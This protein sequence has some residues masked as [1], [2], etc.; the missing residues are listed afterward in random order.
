MSTPYLVGTGV[1]KLARR[2]RHVTLR[3]LAIVL[4][5]AGMSLGLAHPAPALAAG[6]W[7][8]YT[9]GSLNI[10]SAPSTA[11]AI[12]GM[13]N[14]GDSVAVSDWVAGEVVL[15]DNG[16]WG[17]LG[18]GMYVYSAMLRK[19]TD[20]GPAPP[21]ANAFQGRDWIDVNTTQQTIAAYAGDQLLYWAVVSTG[22]PNYPSPQGTFRILRRVENETM[23]N[24]G[25]PWITDSYVVPNVLFTQ[26]FTSLGAALHYNYWKTENSP[27]GVPTS[28]GC[29]GLKY[30][31][32]NWFWVWAKVGTPVVVHP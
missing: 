7:I 18:P 22:R 25:L 9:S 17:M 23:T 32:A 4:L 29:V 1:P 26:Y 19:N 15:E 30:D 5:V 12:V 3:L 24:A 13:L 16:T 14:A 2:A 21:P 31:D 28:H 10:R 11:S 20:V 6:P 8:G 27:W